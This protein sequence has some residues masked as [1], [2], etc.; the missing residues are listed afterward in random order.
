[1]AEE[2][3]RNR[4]KSKVRARQIP[5]LAL[6]TLGGGATDDKSRA[7]TADLDILI[8]AAGCRS[9]TEFNLRL[10]ASDPA[11]RTTIGGTSSL[12]HLE[13]Y[14][15]AARNPAPLPAEIYQKVEQLQIR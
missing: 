10:A 12:A 5:A 14:L 6:R 2:K 3:E 13:E 4:Q 9:V 7:K 15:M 8:K 1:L 11:I